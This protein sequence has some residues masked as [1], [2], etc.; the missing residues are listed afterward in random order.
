ML[1]AFTDAR[2]WALNPCK[3]PQYGVYG[4]DGQNAL[5]VDLVDA[6]WTRCTPPF[7]FQISRADTGPRRAAGDGPP[8]PPDAD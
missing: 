7:A 4:R 2:E 8:G 3:Q 6:E 1:R 5:D